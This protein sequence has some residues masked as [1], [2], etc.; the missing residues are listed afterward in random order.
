MLYAPITGQY[1]TLKEIN[2]GVFS[3]GMLGQG[4]GI[5]PEGGVVFSPVNGEVVSIADSKHAVG[6]A[7]EDG[8]ELL[9]HIGLDTVAIKG[10]GFMPLVKTGDKVKAGQRVLEFD[11]PGI[12]AAG[13]PTTSAFIIT[14][15]DDC[16]LIDIKTGEHYD[17]A[18]VFGTV[19]A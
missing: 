17:A 11:M 18:D 3:E 16:K 13:H 12:I 4:Y 2:D 1:I 14:N 6:I 9:I 19:E 5:I 10:K 8:A 7:S 15:S